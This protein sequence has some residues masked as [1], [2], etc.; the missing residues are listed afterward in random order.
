MISEN[1][2][3]LREGVTGQADVQRAADLVDEA[4]DL[5]GETVAALEDGVADQAVADE[6][7]STLRRAA[8]LEREIGHIFLR[9]SDTSTPRS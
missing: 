8:A 3:S 7:G 6:M 2:A 9:L 1:V 4:A 5:Y